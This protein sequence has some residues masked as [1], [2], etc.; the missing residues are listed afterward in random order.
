[1]KNNEFGF[2]L[3]LWTKLP[4]LR[5]WLLLVR[6]SWLTSASV[7]AGEN[8]GEPKIKNTVADEVNDISESFT[9]M[10]STF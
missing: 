7:D 4:V 6:F 5:F 1:M 8:E 2:N 10:E 9:H 3:C